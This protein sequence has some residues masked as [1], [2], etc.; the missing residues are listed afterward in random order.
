MKVHK[1]P[2]VCRFKFPE[3]L[4]K[5]TIEA[6]MAL[7]IVAAEC[8]FGQA[9]VRISAGYCITSHSQA[10]DSERYQVA[11]DVSTDVGEFIAQVFTGLVIRQLGEDKF[12]V[13]RVGSEEQLKEAGQQ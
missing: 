11:I 6:Q 2:V 8:V 4:D 3:G 7:A 1:M 9:K 5:D 12:T 10:E 13:D